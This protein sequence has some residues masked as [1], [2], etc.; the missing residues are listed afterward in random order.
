MLIYDDIK[1]IEEHFSV[2]EKT[3]GSWENYT[4]GYFMRLSP[5]Q[6]ISE[7]DVFTRSLDGE[8]P[9]ASKQYAGYCNRRRELIAIDELLRN[10]G[11]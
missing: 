4:N 5:T 2:I 11:R 7:I 1:P 6:R 9:R 3:H 10:V 8:K